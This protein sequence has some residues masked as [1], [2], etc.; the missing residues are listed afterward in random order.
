MLSKAQKKFRHEKKRQQV[1][2]GKRIFA[3]DSAIHGKRMAME[4]ST[5][6]IVGTPVPKIA[7]EEK[8]LPT[9]SQE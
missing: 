6:A 4:A 2:R 1:R 8:D 9:Q 7:T 5:Q 3:H